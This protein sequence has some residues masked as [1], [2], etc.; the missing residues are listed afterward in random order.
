MPTTFRVATVS[1]VLL[2]G[3]LA[4][5]LS[6]CPKQPEVGETTPAGPVAAAPAP[7]PSG[8]PRPPEAR[9]TPPPAPREATVALPPTARPGAAAAPP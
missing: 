2:I 8:S 4:L 7:L 9:V 1:P 5:V 6:G 3:A